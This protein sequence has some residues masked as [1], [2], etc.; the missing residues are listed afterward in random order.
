MSVIRG[1]MMRPS[2]MARYRGLL[3][4]QHRDL[5]VYLTPKGRFVF[6]ADS[7]QAG[8]VYWIFESLREAGEALDDDRARLFDRRLIQAAESALSEFLAQAQC[9]AD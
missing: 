2:E 6:Y 8:D 4:A 3:L 7:K 5:S 1:G 9:D